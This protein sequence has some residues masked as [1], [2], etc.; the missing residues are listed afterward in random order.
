MCLDP[1]NKIRH[2]QNNATY[3]V[4]AWRKWQ[5]FCPFYN[6]EKLLHLIVLTFW[7]GNSDI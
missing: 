1:K 5:K 4:D 6:T 7:L 2:H 3:F